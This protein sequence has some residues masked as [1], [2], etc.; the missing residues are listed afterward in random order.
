MKYRMFGVA[1]VFAALLPSAALA[2]GENTVGEAASA[3]TE[4]LDR[5]GEEDMEVTTQR[6]RDG[7]T[8]YELGCFVGRYVFGLDEICQELWH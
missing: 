1:L 2:Q 8:G 7:S 3:N 6:Y 5:V 4:Q